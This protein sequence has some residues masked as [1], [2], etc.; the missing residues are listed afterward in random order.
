MLNCG[1][2][3][4]GEC[5]AEDCEDVRIH[6]AF[7]LIDVGL[8]TLDGVIDVGARGEREEEEDEPVFKWHVEYYYLY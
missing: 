8:D 1:F 2:K 7:E 4:I 5:L 3:G 6:G